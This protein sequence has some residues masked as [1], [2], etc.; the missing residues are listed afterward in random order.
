MTIP[1]P[2]IHHFTE[3]NAG[4]YA[5]VKH[6]ELDQVENGTSLLAEKINISKDRK[7]AKSAPDYWLKIR[8]GKKWSKPL[9]GLFK[10]SAGNVFHG[11]CN[12]KKHLILAKFS[13]DGNKITVL[14]FRD[15]FTAD[16]TNVL[17]LT[18]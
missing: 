10:T 6:Y 5:G 11:D 18:Q 2:T 8:E 1:A 9:T 12:Y 17:H 7:F 15:F 3:I 16:L 14:Y 13:E 4:K